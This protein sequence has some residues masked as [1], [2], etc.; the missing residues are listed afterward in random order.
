MKIFLKPGDLCVCDRP[1][2][3]ED[4]LLHPYGQGAFHMDK[5]NTP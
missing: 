3:E 1:N 2:G 4:T 5:E